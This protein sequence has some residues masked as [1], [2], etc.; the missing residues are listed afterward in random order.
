MLLFHVKFMSQTFFTKLKFF[1]RNLLPK[2]HTGFYILLLSSFFL[3]LVLYLIPLCSRIHAITLTHNEAVVLQ[4]E[5]KL[6]ALIHLVTALIMFL[7]LFIV[8]FVI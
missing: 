6:E 5:R 3:L 4:W 8:C 2:S 1:R 7:I